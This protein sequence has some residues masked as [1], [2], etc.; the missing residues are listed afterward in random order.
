MV[1]NLRSKGYVRSCG[2]REWNKIDANRVLMYKILKDK[3]KK[4][5]EF[6]KINLHFHSKKS[7]W[8]TDFS[9]A[10]TLH[11]Y[12]PKIKNENLHFQ[13]SVVGTRVNKNACARLFFLYFNPNYIQ[14]L[15]GC[16][17]KGNAALHRPKTQT[18]ISI[19]D[20]A[21]NSQFYW[22]FKKGQKIHCSLC[23]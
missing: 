19:S 17:P 23:P 12:C 22:L 5:Y 14:A 18:L 1:M 11:R 2:G 21:L 15:N 8:R 7:T 10:I 9:E 20:C 16:M 3:K 6:Q 13:I 4:H